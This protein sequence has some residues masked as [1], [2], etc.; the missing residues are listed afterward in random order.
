MMCGGIAK[1]IGWRDIG[2]LHQ[3]VIPSS[4]KAMKPNKRVYYR[5]AVCL[6]RLL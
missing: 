1:T 2:N 4:N 3:A 6:E 5:C